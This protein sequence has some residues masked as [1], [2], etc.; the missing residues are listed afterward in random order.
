M[1]LRNYTHTHTYVRM[2]AHACTNIYK[3]GYRSRG[4]PEGSLFNSYYTVGAISREGG[5]PFPRLLHFTLDPNLIMLSFK[6]DGFKYHF[7]VFGMTR[8]GIEPWSSGPLTNTLLCTQLYSIYTQNIFQF[9][10]IIKVLSTNMLIQFKIILTI[11]S[12]RS[13]W[14]IAG[15]LAGNSTLSQSKSGSNDTE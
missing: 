1:V 15:N 6:Q 9:V 10:A 14:A 3:V 13:I 7:W 2:R 4:R 11:I 8:P 5:T 12:N